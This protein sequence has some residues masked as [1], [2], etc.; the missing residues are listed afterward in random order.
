VEGV[1]EDGNSDSKKR[2]MKM[3]AFARLTVFFLLVV[4][5]VLVGCSPSTKVVGSG[6][7]KDIDAG[8]LNS[9]VGFDGLKFTAHS[10]VNREEFSRQYRLKGDWWNKAFQFL[11]ATDLSS[12]APGIYVVDSGNVIA[13]V[14]QVAT[15]DLN[16]VNWEAHRNFNDLQYVITGKAGMG[17]APVTDPEAK[18]SKPYA[19][20]GDTETFSSA[21][22]V[23][24]DTAPGVYFIF[25]P[26]EI[27][28]PAFRI[29][30]FDSV[31]K[32]VIKVRVPGT[33]M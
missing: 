26:R 12:M 33:Q 4:S 21:K 10:S 17:V 18:V 25:S 22:G 9:H 28:R 7:S 27:H 20:T 32:V 8:W 23:Y 11:K 29:E 30:G 15:K 6:A 24:Y 14:S 1:P 3:K 2:K 19:T 5:N 31:K 13:T 16:L